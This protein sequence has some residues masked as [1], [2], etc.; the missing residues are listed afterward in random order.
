MAGSRPGIHVRIYPAGRPGEHCHGRVVRLAN[1][2]EADNKARLKD[3]FKVTMSNEFQHYLKITVM[4]TNSKRTTESISETN[5][6]SSNCEGGN[7]QENLP[8]C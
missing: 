6:L 1:L 4:T 8:T 3:I 5:K 7:L 2:A